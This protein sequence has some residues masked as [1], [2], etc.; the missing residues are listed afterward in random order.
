MGSQPSSW[1]LSDLA[2]VAFQ[3]FTQEIKDVV[4][5]YLETGA[6]GPLLMDYPSN[7]SQMHLL[8]NQAE[9]EERR[10]KQTARDKSGQ[11]EATF[12]GYLYHQ[13]REEEL[14]QDSTN[15]NSKDSKTIAPSKLQQSP[16]QNI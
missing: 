11:T 1:K 12:Q 10:I 14:L 13:V 8:R 5:E 9:K 6:A 3:A 7:L 2:G 4:A 16:K 15:K